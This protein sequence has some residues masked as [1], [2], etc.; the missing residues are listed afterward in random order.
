[1]SKGLAAGLC[2]CSQC[3]IASERHDKSGQG[4]GRRSQRPGRTSRRSIYPGRC[5]GLR[6]CWAFSPL[7][8]RLLTTSEY[9]RKLNKIGGTR[10]RE[11][12]KPP[13]FHLPLPSLALSFNKIGCSRQREFEKPPAFHLPLLSLALSL[14]KIG[15]ARQREIEKPPAFHPPLLSLALSLPRKDEADN[16]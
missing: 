1:M 10:Q 12:E 3:A 2:L 5:P 9:L 13:A 4:G 11:I 8:E 6:A 7:L 16:R 14:N 15:G